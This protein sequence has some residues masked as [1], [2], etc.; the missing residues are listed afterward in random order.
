[1][2]FIRTPASGITFFSERCGGAFFYGRAPCSRS[3]AGYVPTIKV[4]AWGYELMTASSK[5]AIV[6]VKVET[7]R[8]IH[9]LGLLFLGD[10]LK[11]AGYEVRVFN[12][13]ESEREFAIREVLAMKPL[14]V[15]LSTLTGLQTKYTYEISKAMK[16]RDPALR[17]VWGGVHPSMLPEDCLKEDCVDMVCLGEG[18]ETIV[19]LADRL[20][21]GK[22]AASVKG[23]G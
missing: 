4:C 13:F 7:D 10:A 21:E 2:V 20:T 16:E 3:R 14:F 1:M 12:I 17:I 8:V 5:G 15:G 6:L 23:I 18:E 11:K 19:E 9:P 22:G